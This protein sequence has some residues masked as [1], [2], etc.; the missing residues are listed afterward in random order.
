MYQD[1]VMLM[2]WT[3]TCILNSKD[4][5]VEKTLDDHVNTTLDL[6]S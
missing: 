1:R 5:I 3:V 2:I 4:S 6:T